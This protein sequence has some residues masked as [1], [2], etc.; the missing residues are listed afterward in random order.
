MYAITETLPNGLTFTA[1]TRVLDGNP[2]TE[3][4]VTTY[5]YT[6]TDSD[7]TDPDTALTALH[8]HHRR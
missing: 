6:A 7:T 4:A 5:T 3:Q 2:T 8:H 1:A